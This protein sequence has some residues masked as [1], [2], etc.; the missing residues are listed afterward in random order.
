MH[1]RANSVSGGSSG[2]RPAP[3]TQSGPGQRST[4]LGRG[5]IRAGLGRPTFNTGSGG[6]SPGITAQSLRLPSS[7]L[8]SSGPLPRSTATA[9]PILPSDAPTP[10]GDTTVSGSAPGPVASTDQPIRAIGRYNLNFFDA[11]N[12]YESLPRRLEQ[13]AQRRLESELSAFNDP[14][15]NSSTARRRRPM[16]GRIAANPQH[17][18]DAIS[19]AEFARIP[20]ETLRDLEP[21]FPSQG[22][23]SSAIPAPTVLQRSIQCSI[24]LES[25]RSH[26]SIIVLPLCQHGF[27]A[28]CIRPWFVQHTTCPLCRRSVISE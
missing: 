21:A 12:E 16:S 26:D 8:P 19:D 9:S 7:D 15:A 18:P 4:P 24:C 3:L 11:R 1:R 5:D 10:S 22:L 2:R 13:L 14:H 25:T 6:G 23:P 20:Y 27:H 28:T 17:S